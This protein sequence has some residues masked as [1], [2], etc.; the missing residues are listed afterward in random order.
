[1]G[2]GSAVVHFG[3]THVALGAHVVTNFSDRLQRVYIIDEAM[4][5]TLVHNRAC[6][7][8]TATVLVSGRPEIERDRV[9]VA[10]ETVTS[11]QK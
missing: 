3:S 8:T 5:P 11:D 9:L 4:Q 1:M 2:L 6:N 10:Q 7:K